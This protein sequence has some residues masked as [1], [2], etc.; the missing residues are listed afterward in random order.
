MLGHWLFIGQVDSLGAGMGFS[1]SARTTEEMDDVQVLS[2]HLEAILRWS[3]RDLTAVL[4]GGLGLGW[5]RLSEAGSVVTPTGGIELQYL[6]PYGR[7]VRVAHT[8]SKS[9]RVQNIGRI[10]ALGIIERADARLG[11]SFASAMRDHIVLSLF[12]ERAAGTLDDARIG[13]GGAEFY[14][15]VALDLLK[16]ELGYRMRYMSLIDSTTFG[17]RAQ[18]VFEAT[19]QAGMRF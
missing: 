15:P 3:H 7:V 1:V 5:N 14:I 10:D 18:E 11:F 6:R 17:Q 13:W 19:L 9:R 8:I 12:Y 16:Q 4:R 2:G